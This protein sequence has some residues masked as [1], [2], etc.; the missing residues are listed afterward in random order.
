MQFPW[1]LINRSLDF[2]LLTSALLDHQLDILIVQDTNKVTIR[3]AVVQGNII[4][5]ENIPA[6]DEKNTSIISVFFLEYK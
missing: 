6:R 4:H 3:V 2:V 1:K 5:L